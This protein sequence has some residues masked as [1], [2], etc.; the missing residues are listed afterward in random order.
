MM[1]C[2]Q[3]RFGLVMST[4]TTTLQTTII[5]TVIDVHLTARLST[6][7]HTATASVLRLFQ[8]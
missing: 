7:I 2:S 4:N 1:L 8:L 3:S 6:L 5:V